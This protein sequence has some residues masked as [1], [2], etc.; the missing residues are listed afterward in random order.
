MSLTKEQLL[1]EGIQAKF[2][3]YVQVDSQS[4]SGSS[5]TPSSEEQW[6]MA[7]ML[8][9]ELQTLG[10]EDA[11]LDEFG[12][13][14]GTLPASPGKENAPAIGYLAHYDTVPGLPAQNVKPIL[15]HN[16]QGQVIQLEDGVVLDP[17]LDASLKEVIGHDIISSDGK[18]LLGADDKSGVAAIMEALCMFIKDPS[19]AHGP[20]KIGFTPDEEVGTGIRN[21]DVK[22]FGAI[23]AYTLD[24]GP[25]GGMQMETF[26]ASNYTIKITGRSTHPGSARNTMI[27]AIHIAGQFCA[28]IPAGMR[29]ETTDDV[30]GYIHPNTIQ[31]TQ[32]EITMQVLI[33]DFDGDLFTAKKLMVE[34][35]V[36]Q[37]EQMNPG[38]HITA[39]DNGGYRNMCE[40]LKEKPE[41]VDIAKA[42]MQ[43]IGYEPQLSKVRGGTD[44][45]QLTFMGLPTPNLF[46]GG[47]SAHARY[48]WA[49]VPWM[50]KAAELILAIAD[51]WSLEK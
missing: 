5:K 46:Y 31:G 50:Q 49:S 34:S 9:E 37:L 14:T 20:F 26:N 25:A 36:K 10:I 7:K 48:E 8:F 35:L 24:G 41:I 39:I 44:G 38:S 27:N 45:S 17:E 43:K 40:I 47:S 18:T 51:L 30:W 12:F 21:F 16:Y 33:R 22:R 2:L 4:Q 42:A 28:M 11:L 3:R 13:V 19:L 6:N 1:Q 15:H 32:E 23:A 29:P